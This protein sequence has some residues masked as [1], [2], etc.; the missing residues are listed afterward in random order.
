MGGQKSGG[1]GISTLKFGVRTPEFGGQDP[2]LSIQEP[3]FGVLGSPGPEIW[4]LQ[5]AN[6]REETSLPD[7]NIVS[8]EC[9]KPANRNKVCLFN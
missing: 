3:K 7:E 6:S 9:L 8:D 1:W 4:G 5:D 2:K